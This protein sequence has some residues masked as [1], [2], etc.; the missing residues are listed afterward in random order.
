MSIAIDY[1]SGAFAANKAQG[2]GTVTAGTGTYNLAVASYDGVSFSVSSQETDG[3]DIFFKPDGTKLYMVGTGGD[4]V[5]EYSLSTAWDLS[6]ASYVQSFSVSTQETGP[7]GIF[8]KGDGTKMYITGGVGDDVNEYN[9]STAWDISTAS[10][11]QNFSVSAQ[12]S[13][14]RAIFFKGDGTKMFIADQSGSDINE[15]GLSTAWDVSSAS[16]TQ[17]FSVSSQSTSPQAVYFNPYGT[18]MFVG[19]I[20]ADVYKYSLSTGWDL[21]TASYDSITFDVSSQNTN[22]LGLFFK[23][24]GSKMYTMDSGTDAIYQYSTGTATSL[25]ISSGTYFN[26][27]PT[28][29]TT[30]TFA[31]APAS[32]TAAG[33]AL[34]VTGANGAA[35]YDIANASRDT[36]PTVNFSVNAQDATPTEIAFNNDGTKMYMVGLNTDIIYQY[37]LST[38]YNPSTASYNSVSFSVAIQITR[39]N[40]IA[41]NNDGTK[42]F[43]S[44]SLDSDT[45]YQYSLSTAF[46]LS[47]ASYNSVSFSFAGQDTRPNSIAFNNDGTK[48]FMAGTVNDSIY[49]YSLSTAF[50]VSTISYDSVSFSVAAQDG[51]PQC[52]AFNNDGTKLFMLGGSTD[53]IYQYS[54][55]TA[56][57]I[58]TI[59]Y[60]SVSFS[61]ASREST[62]TGLTF[63]PD[64]TKMYIVGWQ[65][66][67][68]DQ[69]TTGSTATAT[70]SYPAS[71]EWPSGTAPDGPAIGETDVLVFLTDDGGTSYQG[72]QAGDAMS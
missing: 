30:F 25:D 64:G 42:M 37:S 35:V 69:Y 36:N 65:R 45:V 3:H 68:V 38:A 11:L 53:S 54:L 67:T 52:I 31:N 28:A 51:D 62:P 44:G 18:E 34:A 15:Y 9:L 21:S 12:I 5:N 58:S 39:P 32:G 57:D 20:A 26:Y 24:D 50:D 19:D 43:I 4:D 8:F 22:L 66:D 23:S 59:S 61:V 10:Y 60:D 71:V 41:F 72:F 63:K 13:L 16:F 17:T 27:T 48:L 2:V 40:G 1:S 46:D 6:T 70:F 47:T 33:F 29:N 56:F 14:P 55:S 7:S 49:Q